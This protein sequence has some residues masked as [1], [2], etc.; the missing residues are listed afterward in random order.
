MRVDL[1]VFWATGIAIMMGAC[2]ATARTGSVQAGAAN[3]RDPD[4]TAGD[5]T[6]EKDRMDKLPRP[7]RQPP[8]SS[9]QPVVVGDVRYESD[10]AIIG[11]EPSRSKVYMVTAR[12]AKTG[13]KLWS[14]TVYEVKLVPGLETDVQGRQF[15]SMAL[16]PGNKQLLIVDEQGGRYTV[17]LE[18][19]TA[20]TVP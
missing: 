3:V 18:R 16:M 1:L 7:S 14:V 12:N 11:K 19:R 2:A 6:Q 20:T 10:G 13:E 5:S 15:A 4:L 17:D 9:A 8:K